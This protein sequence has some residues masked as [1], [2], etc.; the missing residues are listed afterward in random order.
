MP[1]R[2]PLALPY[3]SLANFRV[4]AM[5]LDGYWLS[6][7]KWGLMF[8]KRWILTHGGWYWNEEIESPKT[9]EAMRHPSVRKYLTDSETVSQNN[10]REPRTFPTVQPSQPDAHC[11]WNEV[12]PLAQWPQPFVPQ[13]LSW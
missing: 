4:Y 11:H 3:C 8:C 1:Q 10:E 2:A 5:F 6:I 12:N 13:P 7:Y 9:F